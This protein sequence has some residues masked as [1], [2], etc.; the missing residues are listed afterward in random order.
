MG[1]LGDGTTSSSS[2]PVDV[3]GL[4]SGVASVDGG[5]KHACAV[6]ASGGLKCWGQN[7]SGQLGDGT[8]TEALAPVDV[9]GLASGVASVTASSWDHTCALMASGSV[10]CWG[11]NDFGQLG[12]GT[13][14]HRSTPVD[15]VGLTGATAVTSGGRYSCALT[16]GGGVKCWG[17]GFG[18]AP[19][20]VV[21]LSSG[22]ADLSASVYHLCAVTTGGGI[23]CRGQN[24]YGQLGDGT[25]ANSVT[26]VD[27]VGFAT[28]GAAVAAG[29]F[30]T[31]AATTVGG[32]KC[33]GF[34]RF[35]ELGNGTTSGFDANPVPVDVVELTAKPTATSTPCGPEGCPTPTDTATPPPQA[36]LDFSLGIDVDGDTADD[37]GTD[38]GAGT[39]CSVPV[40]SSFDLKVYLNSLPVDV[41]GYRGFDIRLDYAGVTSN[42]DASP[43]PWPDCGTP[44]SFFGPDYLAFGCGVGPGAP[45][46]TYAG[47]IGIASFTCAKPGTI[48]MVHGWPNT[49]LYEDAGTRHDE[50]DGA[51]ETLSLNCVE[52]PP[53]PTVPPVG[54]IGV[55][56]DGTGSDSPVDGAVGILGGALAASLAGA[57][58]LGGA[59]SFVRRRWAE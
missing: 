20:D 45:P 48:T 16:S 24:T 12:D 53:T 39:K 14:T 32:A 21:G 28:S 44:A 38:A 57:I 6:T 9:S 30:H 23:K 29:Y 25:T 55:L 31:C 13:T 37:C 34:N 35:G 40:D 58:A 27:V 43:G 5:N 15:V 56:P 3:V 41:T 47:L 1:Q 51:T 19:V 26:P 46:S 36:G 42:D 2:V 7:A 8:T 17:F 18:T 33:W 50:G 49:V 59:A 22:V 4:G 10:K 54:G 52:L 11:Y